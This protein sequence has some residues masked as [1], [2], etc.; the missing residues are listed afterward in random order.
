MTD[1]HNSVG[2][3]ERRI[4]NIVPGGIF[5]ST[6]VDD[7]PHFPTFGGR[8]SLP[9]N[10][11]A[12]SGEIIWCWQYLTSMLMSKVLDAW[13][14][15]PLP[16]STCDF[17]ILWCGDH[18]IFYVYVNGRFAPA[19]AANE[20][21][22]SSQRAAIS[23]SLSDVPSLCCCFRPRLENWSSAVHVHARSVS[24]QTEN[25]S[26]VG[27]LTVNNDSTLMPKN[28]LWRTANFVCSV[29]KS[30]SLFALCLPWRISKKAYDISLNILWFD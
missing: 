10:M 8:H 16:L 7:F 29:E 27:L 21:R 24:R 5:M 9:P 22:A 14:R 3:D 20:R 12:Q 19:L 23:L 6:K 18:K 30:T 26:Q 11:H 4:T 17:C 1:L 28:I 25:A 15:T 2:V 13:D